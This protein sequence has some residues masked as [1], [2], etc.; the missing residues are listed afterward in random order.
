MKE[1]TEKVEVK[2]YITDDGRE[3]KLDV[4]QFNKENKY[5]AEKHNEK[6]HIMY[7]Y[8]NFNV[9]FDILENEELNEDTLPHFKYHLLRLCHITNEIYFIDKANKANKEEFKSLLKNL[10]LINEHLGYNIKDYIIIDNL[11]DYKIAD[12]LNLIKPRDFQLF[13][14]IPEIV[15]Y[16]LDKEECDLTGF[17][18]SIFMDISSR[19]SYTTIDKTKVKSIKIGSYQSEPFYYSE[20]YNKILDI[21]IEKIGFEKLILKITYDCGFFMETI[22][23]LVNLLFIHTKKRR[24]LGTTKKSV[25]AFILFLYSNFEDCYIDGYYAHYVKYEYK[26]TKIKV[27][28]KELVEFLIVNKSYSKEDY[29]L[30]NLYDLLSYLGLEKYKIV[31]LID[32]KY[33]YDNKD[34]ENFKNYVLSKIDIKIISYLYSDNGIEVITDS[35]LKKGKCIV[36]KSGLLTEFEVIS[37]SKIN[38]EGRYE[39]KIESETKY[40][41]EDYKELYEEYSKINYKAKKEIYDKINELKKELKKYD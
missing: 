11:K 4:E 24:F 3:Y 22:V 27:P 15:K 28:T 12:K 18:R 17:I 6:Y 5:K 14:D 26:K 37:A 2:K 13:K 30:K 41:L 32:T 16:I 25:L 38:D 40:N 9:N 23:D 35:A 36:M 29:N 19:Y 21:L 39:T 33:K 1:L 31:Y 8:N 20:I 10:R 7:N 34:L